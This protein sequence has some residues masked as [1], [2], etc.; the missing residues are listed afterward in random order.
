LRVVVGSGEGRKLPDVARMVKEFPAQRE[1]TEQGDL[2][3]GLSVR[4][5]VAIK[6]EQG[7]AAAELQLGEGAKFFPSNEALAAWR[8][9]AELGQ[10]AIVYE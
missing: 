5:A 3:R 7:A 4:L 10:A 1:E 2:L 6:G 9:Q 8:V